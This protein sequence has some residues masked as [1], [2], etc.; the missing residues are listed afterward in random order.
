MKIEIP[1][2][3]IP[4]RWER[5]PSDQLIIE[6]D[7]FWHPWHSKWNEVTCLHAGTLAV[8]Y[9]AFGSPVIRKKETT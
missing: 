4:E 6:G 2:V 3:K 9:E 7:M 5:V 1:I 8:T